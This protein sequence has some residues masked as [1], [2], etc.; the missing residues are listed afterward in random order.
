MLLVIES[1]VSALLVAGLYLLT[2]DHLR[3]PSIATVSAISK[4]SGHRKTVKEQFVYPFARRLQKIIRLSP[5]RRRALEARLISADIM[6][7]P[8]FYT[9][10]A[11][12]TSFY[13]LAPALALLFFMPFLSF[14][15][16][17]ISVAV[18]LKEYY[19]ADEYLRKRKEMIEVE[20]P[21]LAATVA[22]S[23][24]YRQDILP[25]LQNQAKL[26]GKAFRHE[27]NL[28]IT[29]MRTGNRTAALLKFEGRL[30]SELTSQL[31]RGLIGVERGEDMSAYMQRMLINMK[32][33]E[34]SR[35]GKEAK[36]RPHELFG[37]NTFLL[38][39]IIVF[40]IVVMGMQLIISIRTMY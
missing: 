12:I 35:L 37:A 29:D 10:S 33:H 34:L 20:I 17:L 27:L 38:I 4:L 31:V 23:Q 3:L 8:E 39:S 1:L 40:Y 28:L 16:I 25:V 24:N 9:A 19:A 2:Q 36:K 13:I 15:L 6:F 22:E 26:C 21:R 14:P 5:Y 11:A 32:G 18:F 7:T 30:D